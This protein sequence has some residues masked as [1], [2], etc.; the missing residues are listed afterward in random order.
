[1]RKRHKLRLSVF[2]SRPVYLSCFFLVGPN[3]FLITSHIQTV[4]VVLHCGRALPGWPTCTAVLL[5]ALGVVKA[6]FPLPPSLT[7]HTYTHTQHSLLT[8]LLTRGI[9]QSPGIHHGRFARA[10][11]IINSNQKYFTENRKKIRNQLISN[12]GRILNTGL[13]ITAAFTHRSLNYY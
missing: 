9:E 1:M 8:L 7:P 6:A 5:Y 3:S 2:A 13:K 10:I 4:C 11:S 12:C